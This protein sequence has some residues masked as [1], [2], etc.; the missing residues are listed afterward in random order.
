MATAARFLGATTVNGAGAWSV[1]VAGG[2]DGA[3]V[4]ATATD[5]TGNTS[6]FGR[7]VALLG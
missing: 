4:T 1:P 6:A 2:S 3:V 7:N 5:A